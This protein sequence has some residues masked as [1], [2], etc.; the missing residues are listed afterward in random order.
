M[1]T[2]ILRISTPKNAPILESFTNHST[3]DSERFSSGNIS[4]IK[5]KMLKF[6]S[7]DELHGIFFVSNAGELKVKEI[8]KIGGTSLGFKIPEGVMADREY[9][10]VVRSKF[11]MNYRSGA[12]EGILVGA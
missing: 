12:L 3:G 4:S 7:V 10:L 11:G 6:D 5:G 8:F 2:P 9:N 1:C